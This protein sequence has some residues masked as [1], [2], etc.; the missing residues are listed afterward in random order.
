MATAEEES[1]PEDTQALLSPDAP[2]PSV[3]RSVLT[4]L[5]YTRSAA[6]PRE[7]TAAGVDQGR[8][9]RVTAFGASLLLAGLLGWGL[10]QLCSK[11]GPQTTSG[12][13]PVARPPGIQPADAVDF[14]IVRTPACSA[15]PNCSASNPGGNC[16]P[17]NTGITL[18]CCNSPAAEA[19]IA[20]VPLQFTWGQYVIRTN[21]HPAPPQQSAPPE[22]SPG[23]WSPANV[24]I[25]GGALQLSIERNSGYRWIEGRGMV[26]DDGP[27]QAWAF[28][29]AVVD[30]QL[31]FGT[32]VATLAIVD[33]F[34]RSAWDAFLAKDT[35]IAGIFT[36]DLAGGWTGENKFGELDI[37]EVGY[38][39]QSKTDPDAWINCQPDGPAF[40]PASNAHF[41]VQPV[42]PERLPRGTTANYDH[43]H[44]FRLDLTKLPASGE[45]TFAMRWIGASAPVKF[46]AVPGAYNSA[47]FPW[48]GADTTTWTTPMRA[49]GDVPAPSSTMRLHVNLWGYQ[50]PSDNSPAYIRLT[51]LEMP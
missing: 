33:S 49:V 27:E 44:R 26:S 30:R 35:L 40:P 38:Q 42:K 39:N 29:E 1:E 5:F 34:G 47:S 25:V 43:V 50:G 32:Y 7:V 22:V 3:S 10:N 36:Y 14:Q 41:A 20:N 46:W 8:K 6:C 17:T 51:H 24:K 21:Y 4:G 23:L 48:D 37:L 16:C 2:G 15:Y 31:S 19:K 13:K 18:D 11:V 9:A 28:A 45:A 12:V